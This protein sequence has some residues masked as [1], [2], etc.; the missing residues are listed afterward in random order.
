MWPRTCP[1]CRQEL[2]ERGN[3]RVYVPWKRGFRLVHAG[4]CF[5]AIDAQGVLETTPAKPKPLDPLQA[6][7]ARSCVEAL[8]QRHEPLK[9][10]RQ[11]LTAIACRR[12]VRLQEE[13]VRD[14]GPDQLE[15][16]QQHAAQ[17]VH[18]FF[19]HDPEVSGPTRTEPL[20]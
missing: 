13:F 11:K 6:V 8:L 7:R 5:D 10:T 3:R 2:P 1:V 14:E 12:V 15:R 17:L 9:H 16:L 18:R 20:A 4:A 19:G